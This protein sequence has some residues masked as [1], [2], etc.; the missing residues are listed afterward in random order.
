MRKLYDIHGIEDKLNRESKRFK[1]DLQ[2]IPH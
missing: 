1:K 2:Q